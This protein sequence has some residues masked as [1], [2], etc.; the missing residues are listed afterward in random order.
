MVAALAFAAAQTPGLAANPDAERI[1]LDV[2]QIRS[3]SAVSDQ[4]IRFQMR[5]GEVWVNTLK[6]ECPGLRFENAFA[7]DVSGGEVCSNTE[8]IYV[9]NRG[10]PCQLGEFRRAEPDTQR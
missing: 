2:S 6:R 10:T 3:R 5:N 4:E 8:T 7:W 1:C 9:L